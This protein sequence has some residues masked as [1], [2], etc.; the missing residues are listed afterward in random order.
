[1]S[2]YNVDPYKLDGR[3]KDEFIKDLERGLKN[4]AIAIRK[5]EEILSNSSG[6]RTPSIVYIGS[7]V[8]GKVETDKNGIANVSVFP[9]YLVKYKNNSLRIGYELIEV[10]VCNPKS[11]NAY[12]KKKQIEQYA[13][14]NNV[15]IL[16]VMGMSTTD[17][18]FIIVRPQDILGL[19]IEPEIIYGKE[20]FRVPVQMF[21]W[22][23]FQAFERNYNPLTKDYIRGN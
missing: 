13:E 15:L 6:V 19:G 17:P 18:N 7:D 10:K 4:E 16:F 2:K 21:Y 12:F 20:T 1:M 23:K 9:D 5:F 8:E 11:P 14:I 22:E 3:T